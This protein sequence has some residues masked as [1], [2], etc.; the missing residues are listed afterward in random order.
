[1]PNCM[2]LHHRI[3][4]TKNFPF[5]QL[6]KSKTKKKETQTSQ[7]IFPLQI[8]PR[9]QSISQNQKQIQTYNRCHLVNIVKMT[10]DQNEEK[11]GQCVQKQKQKM[12]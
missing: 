3:R 7:E 6:P 9:N 12:S 8:C 2:K 5:F 4:K 11:H 10:F 1:M